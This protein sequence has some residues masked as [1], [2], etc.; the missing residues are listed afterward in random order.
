MTYEH[1]DVN[2]RKHD[3]KHPANPNR[4]VQVRKHSRRQRVNP[5]N[6]NERNF[7]M[8]GRPPHEE[9]SYDTP[10]RGRIIWS[11]IS[12]ATKMAVGA[13][14][15]VVDDET[16]YLHFRVTKKHGDFRKIIVQLTP[17][18]SYDVKLVNINRR[19]FDTIT[20][21]D[22]QGIYAEDLSSTIYDMVHDTGA[23]RPVEREE[24]SQRKVI[25]IAERDFERGRKDAEMGIA[26]LGTIPNEGPEYTERLNSYM[27]GVEKWEHGHGGVKT[28][29]HYDDR[30]MK[31]VPQS[32]SNSSEVE[33]KKTGGG[34]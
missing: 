5:Q 26:D 18:D 31:R 3:R 33:K 27:R 9:P 7:L 19:S 13:R 30:P 17:M 11:Q 15:I 8:A 22:V 32:E 2:V 12:M 28:W 34:D 4:S 14:D 20:E 1:R 29:R 6:Q 10:Q 16:G 21:H 24:K 23:Y 25:T